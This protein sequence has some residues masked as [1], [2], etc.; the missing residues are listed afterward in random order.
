MDKS[1]GTLLRFW[2]VLQFTQ[3]KPLPLTPQ[4]ML[5]ACI[6]NFSRVSTLYKV[7]GGRTA[8]KFRKGC[9]I[10]RGNRE[11]TEAYEYC[12]TV[13]MTFVQDCRLVE[14]RFRGHFKA[15]SKHHF[16]PLDQV[17]SFTCRFLFTIS[18]HE[19]LVQ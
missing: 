3:V 8:R 7:R 1:L 5:E 11:L 18:I 14:T 13:P 9:T 19:I 15:N 16:F 10:L 6:Q 12:S 17:I 2:G 4:T